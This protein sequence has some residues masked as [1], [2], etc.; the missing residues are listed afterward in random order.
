M[1]MRQTW[2]EACVGEKRNAYRILVRKQEGK[3][4]LGRSRHRWKD[5]IKLDMAC[6]MHRGEEECT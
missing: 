1:R 3:R 2:Y 4:L 6:N 5:N